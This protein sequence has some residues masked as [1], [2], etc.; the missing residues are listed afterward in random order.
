MGRIIPYIMENK[1]CSKPPTSYYLVYD[2][3][4]T[5]DGLVLKKF[6]RKVRCFYLQMRGILLEPT[7]GFGKSAGQPPKIGNTT[8]K[9]DMVF[10]DLPTMCGNNH[11]WVQL[12]FLIREIT[13]C[14]CP[15][16]GKGIK[17]ASMGIYWAYTVHMYI[18]ICIYTQ[19]IM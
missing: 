4:L 3:V 1:K 18:Y 5:V 19:Y 11:D 13:S 7:L 6:C 14:V 2:W 17:L 16:I 10:M 9:M 15:S 8:C 12:F